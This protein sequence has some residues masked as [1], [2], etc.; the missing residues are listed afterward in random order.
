[1][2]HESK[3]G[4][5]LPSP[6]ET[7]PWGGYQNLFEGSGFL[8]KLIEVLPG[9]RLSLQRHECRE[10]F[11]TVIEGRGVAVLN[12]EERRVGPGDAVRVGRRDVHRIANDGGSPLLI[13]ELQKGE[14][15]ED[16]IERL[17]DDFGR[18]SPVSG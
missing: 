3:P 17:E 8:V 11:W 10:E 5:S 14:C 6:S 7:R 12:G 13:L 2:E 1:M 18:S 4:S 9:K 16:D 15:R